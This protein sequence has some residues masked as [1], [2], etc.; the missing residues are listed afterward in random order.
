M[1]WSF[2]LSSIGAVNREL[3]TAMRRVYDDS[4]AGQSLRIILLVW[5][6]RH[7]EV[8]LAGVSK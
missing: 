7:I 6:R 3:N 4:T 1:I 8:R 5:G 2:L